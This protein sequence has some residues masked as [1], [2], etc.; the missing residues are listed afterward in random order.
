MADKA[1]VLGG[2]G[3]TGIAWETGILAG[4]AEHGVDLTDA[5]L[6]VGTS[7][8]SVVG[9]DVRTGHPLAALL[10]AQSL[11]VA[12][13]EVYARMGRAVMLRYAMAVSFTR[14]PVVAGRRIG[15]LAVRSRTETEAERRQIFQTRMPTFDWPAG[16]LKITAVETASG[17]FTVFDAN[18]GVSLIDAVGASCA[19][20]GIWPPVTINGKR[21]MDGGMRSA[22]NADLA[23]GYQRVVVIAPLHQGFGPIVSVASQVRQLEAQGAQ[24][25]VIKPDSAALLAIGKNVLDPANRPGAAAAGYAQAGAQAPAVAAVWNG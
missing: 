11:P 9:V 16:D 10:E 14:K 6:V 23:A 21:Y 15:R 19:V 8:G 3:L 22:T 13:T 7:A 25:V 24:V 20:P 4:L 12:P 2:G 1:L 5:D 18:S 17:E